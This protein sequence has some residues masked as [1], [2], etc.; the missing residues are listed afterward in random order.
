MSLNSYFFFLSQILRSDSPR[1]RVR[2]VL[3]VAERIL[4]ARE[5]GGWGGSASENYSKAL[6][7]PDRQQVPTECKRHPLS[8]QTSLTPSADLQVSQLL[9]QPILCPFP[10][11]THQPLERSVPGRW[12]PGCLLGMRIAVRP[13]GSS[14]ARAPRKTTISLSWPAFAFEELLRFMPYKDMHFHTSSRALYPEH[15]T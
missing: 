4:E 12:G 13:L 15:D 11:R 14:E 1:S 3:C 7:S 5:A 6:Y 2:Q 10:M 8:C 9:R